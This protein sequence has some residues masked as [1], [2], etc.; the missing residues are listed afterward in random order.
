[1]AVIRKNGW[2][3]VQCRLSERTACKPLGVERWTYEPRPDRDIE[4]HEALVKLARQ[5]R[6]TVIEG[7]MC[8][9]NAEAMR[10]T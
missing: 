10:S 3:S 2:S 5:K 8:C 9:L 4:L 7:C 1:M 6:V